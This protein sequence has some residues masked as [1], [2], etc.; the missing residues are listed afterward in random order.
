MA[1]RAQPLAQGEAGAMN[2]DELNLADLKDIEEALIEAHQ[3]LMRAM[4]GLGAGER[5]RFIF[6]VGFARG[7]LE[8]VTKRIYRKADA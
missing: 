1:A 6:K 2:E 8:R 4:V 5:E 7:R 3:A